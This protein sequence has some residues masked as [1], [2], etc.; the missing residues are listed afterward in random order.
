MELYLQSPNTPSLRGAVLRV[1]HLPMRATCPGNLILHDF[2][3][4]ILYGKE[5]KF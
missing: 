4:L 2:I 3:T 5:Y 1:S